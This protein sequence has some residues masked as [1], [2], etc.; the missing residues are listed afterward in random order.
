MVK[1]N[2]IIVIFIYFINKT[3]KHN[4]SVIIK[5]SAS[6][7]IRYDADEFLIPIFLALRQPY[8]FANYF[9][10]FVRKVLVL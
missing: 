8:L 3:L 6:T 2:Q 5:S 4:F 7:N 1:N 9:D 10:S